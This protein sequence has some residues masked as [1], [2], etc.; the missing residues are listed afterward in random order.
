MRARPDGADLLAAAEQALRGEVLPGASAGQ[1]AALLMVCNA[2]RIVM[3]QMQRGEAPAERELA[4]L[5]DLGVVEPDSL[6]PTSETTQFATANT[7]L[8]AAIRE[9]RFDAEPQQSALRRH[10]LCVAEHAVRE[11]N[12]KYLRQDPS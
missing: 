9:G 8:C 4:G 7:R 1:R 2:M 11:S 3:R 5:Q 10:L 12:P 6:A